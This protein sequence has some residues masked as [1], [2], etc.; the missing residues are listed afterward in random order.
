MNRREFMEQLRGLLKTLPY[1]EQED[2]LQ[3][4]E[5]YFDDAG[6]DNEQRVIEELESPEAVAQKIMLNSPSVPAA[7]GWVNADNGAEA[8][9]EKA[10]SAPSGDSATAGSSGYDPSAFER[11]YKNQQMAKQ[12]KSSSWVL[13]LVFILTFPIWFPLGIGL[14]ALIFS[15]AVTALA[16][17]FSFAVTVVALVATVI[18]ALILGIP[19]L[20]YDPLNGFYMLSVA[21]MAAGVALIL[22]PPVGWLCKKGIPGMFRGIGKLFSGSSKK[23]KSTFGKKGVE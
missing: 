18:L 7:Q 23:V 4:Y 8:A 17:I 1:G 13:W 14:L 3:F 19:M 15:L 10:N 11:Y 9:S 12:Q 20:F 21:V 5:E 6:V 22:I 16:L 2:A